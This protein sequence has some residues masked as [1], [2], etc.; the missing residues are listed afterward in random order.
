MRTS[1][2]ETDAMAA[3]QT[4]NVLISKSKF[5]A[6]ARTISPVESKTSDSCRC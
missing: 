1:V 6:W 4:K 2:A 3:K 5:C